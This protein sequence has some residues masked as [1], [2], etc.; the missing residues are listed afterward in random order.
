LL[1]SWRARDIA[2]VVSSLAVL[3]AC[4]PG[5]VSFK[6]DV[7]PILDKHCRQCHVPGGPGYTASGFDMS[8]YETFMKGGKFGSFVA[9]GDPLGSNLIW[10]VEGKA[11]PTI[12]MPHGGKKLSDGEI[13]VL[14]TWVQEGA[15]NN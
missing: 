3:G 9:P 10:L 6:S 5:G 1:V 8:S 11:D 7:E 2:A 4:S 12:S 15:K 13:Q 14:R